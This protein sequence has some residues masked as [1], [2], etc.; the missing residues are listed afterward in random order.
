[1]N[2]GLIRASGTGGFHALGRLAHLHG[3]LS[4]TGAAARPCIST[5]DGPG[6][7]VQSADY[8]DAMTFSP[9][10]PGEELLIEWVA[11]ALI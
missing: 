8:G 10:Q 11:P 7:T 9:A 4:Q 6:S 2:M 3:T 1:M 5:T